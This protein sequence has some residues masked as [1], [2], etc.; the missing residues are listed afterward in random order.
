MARA[1]AVVVL[2]AGLLLAGSVFAIPPGAQAEPARFSAS[3][4]A[5]VVA[6]SADGR[7]RVHD[8]QVRVHASPGAASGRFALKAADSA[9]ASC[10]A[11]ANDV[12]SDSFESP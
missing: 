11:L 2:I 10:D 8:A 3:A 9:T 1:P 7:F 4:A 12:F 6:K 5:E